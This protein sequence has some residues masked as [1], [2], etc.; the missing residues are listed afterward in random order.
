MMSVQCDRG[1]TS[2]DRFCLAW[3]PFVDP[4]SI[5]ATGP[6]YHS[7]GQQSGHSV[8]LRCW[9][10]AALERF[11]GRKSAP[12]CTRSSMSRSALQPN[13]RNVIAAWVRRP[14]VKGSN[15]SCEAVFRDT[16]TQRGRISK[17]DRVCVLHQ[18]RRTDHPALCTCR[19]RH[20]KPRL[21]PFPELRHLGLRPRQRVVSP[22]QYR[23]RLSA[24][25]HQ[26]RSTGRIGPRGW[27]FTA[28]KRP[29]H[30]CTWLVRKGPTVRRPRQHMG[31]QVA[32]PMAGCGAAPQAAGSAAP[33]CWYTAVSKP[34]SVSMTGMSKKG[35][36]C[37]ISTP[38]M[39][40]DRSIQ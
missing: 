37:V 21:S 5:A 26:R 12:P 17:K 36:T 32:P 39:P 38:P 13:D 34:M 16:W 9:V 28:R 6:D 25:L 1:S 29:L 14:A 20:D 33:T 4:V 3:P 22:P 40:F 23:I 8:G 19:I 15:R 24:D 31:R 30:S 18:R 11:R 35:S 10:D 2:F 27:N 7:N